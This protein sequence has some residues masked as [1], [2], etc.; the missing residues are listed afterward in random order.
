MTHSKPILYYDIASGPPVRPFAPNPWK[1]RYALNLKRVPYHTEWV[2]LPD[3]TT[4][5]KRLN[6]APVRKFAD[7]SDFH[8]LPVIHD[9][10]HE[11]VVGDS[12]DIAVYLDQTYP[13]SG[14]RLFPQ[15]SS[16]TAL[17]VAFN[18]FVD[19]FFSRFCIL[20]SRGLPFNPETA[21][22]SKAEF[23]RRAGVERWEQLG[24]EGEERI[25]MVEEFKVALD[26]L[27][28]VY[29]HRPAGEGPWLEGGS[30]PTYADLIVGGWLA[31]MKNTLSEWEDMKTWHEGLWGRIDSE[32]ERFAQVH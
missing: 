23:C 31:M 30:S 5:R 22:E 3:V 6:A 11:V 27:A 24:I 32:L 15:A 18:K 19:D 25:K 9:Q 28:R 8:T 26:E 21:D 20:C 16:G 13:E 12:F 1:V 10:G 7:G 14:D 4:V 17:Y 29:K 2:E